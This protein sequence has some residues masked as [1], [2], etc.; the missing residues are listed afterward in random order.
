[1]TRAADKRARAVKLRTLRVKPRLPRYVATLRAV[2][3]M[4]RCRPISVASLQR[5]T[6]VAH[7]LICRQ[8]IVRR[9]AVS[10]A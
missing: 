4:A 1:M 10:P 2:A 5:M 6:L 3:V 8:L 7:R 9:G